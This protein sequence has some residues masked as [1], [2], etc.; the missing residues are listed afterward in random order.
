MK[1]FQN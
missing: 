1:G